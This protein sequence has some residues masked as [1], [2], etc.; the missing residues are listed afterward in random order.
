MNSYV[1][2]W[3]AIGVKSLGNQ[4]RKGT[5]LDQAEREKRSALTFAQQINAAI[6]ISL[7]GGRIH[8]AKLFGVSSTT[9]LRA[10]RRVLSGQ[11]KL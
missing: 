7:G 3:Q 5:T 9:L 11:V 8:T 6:V 2:L 4:H 10:Q 1:Y